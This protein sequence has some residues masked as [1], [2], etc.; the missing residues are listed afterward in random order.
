ML[1]LIY[2]ILKVN[3][4]ICNQF[5]DT[6]PG[7][8]TVVSTRQSPTISEMVAS[9]QCDIGLA[10]Y[11]VEPGGCEHQVFTDAPEICLLPKDHPL[12]EKEEVSAKDFKA[13]KFISLG[14]KDPYAQR[15]HGIF[16][17]QGIPLNIVLEVHNS[18]MAAEA[19]AQGLG[20]TI[21]NP[22]SALSFKHRDVVFRRLSFS[23]PFKSNLIR[24]K[25]QPMSALLRV[26][27]DSL[28]ETRDQYLRDLQI[29]LSK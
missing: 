14:H 28:F 6:R 19:V 1:M 29:L 15:L 22:F 9:Q 5:N 17:T 24:S 8:Q 25:F 10:A 16:E 21:I 7:V 2:W 23:L 4:N 18:I 12:S 3:D 26:F 27:E 11:A 20:V 13:Q